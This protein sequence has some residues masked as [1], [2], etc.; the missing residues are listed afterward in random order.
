M[1]GQRPGPNPAGAHFLRDRAL[2]TRLVAASGAGHDDLV[3]DLGA[4]YGA[5]TGALAAAGC[6]VTAVE[7]DPRLARRLARRFGT[8]P[9][10]RVVEA[11]ILRLPL[12]RR[13]FLVVANI[14]FGAS[15]RLLRR[16]LGDPA[17]PLAGAELITAYG[18]ARWLAGARPR[19]A[20]TAWWAARYRMCLVRRVP[21]ARFGPPPSTDAAQ[22]S[23]RPRP[24]ARSAPAQRVLRTLLRDGFAAR[25]RPVPVGRRV[26]LRAGIAPGTPAAELTAADW[27][28]LAWMLVG[29]A[30]PV[31]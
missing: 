7:R 5:I 6:R 1:S 28:R 11:D 23:V 21:A 16:L 26:L 18:V 29:A 19:D 13:D 4:G 9:R 31:R 25:R 12:P 2:I 14:P 22:L 15:T 30:E 8:D 3:L 17:V 20:E 10:V 24:L 27:H